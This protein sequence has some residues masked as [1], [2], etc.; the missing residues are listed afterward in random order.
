MHEKRWRKLRQ[1]DFCQLY[2]DEVSALEDVCRETHVFASSTYG[3]C[4]VY[5]LE[6]GLAV[7]EAPLGRF[8]LFETEARYKARA[9]IDA[10]ADFS[11]GYWTLE[12]PQEPGL[13]MCKPRDGGPQTVRTLTRTLGRL[14]DVTRG[15]PAPRVGLVSEWRGYWWTPALPALP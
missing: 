5:E 6:N 13:Y 15:E 4:C 12:V 8:S 1:E 14:R 3:T 11:R 7:L 9:H 10:W 2:V